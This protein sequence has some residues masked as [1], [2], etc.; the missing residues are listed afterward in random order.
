[1]PKTLKFKPWLIIKII[2]FNKN[3]N[4]IAFQKPNQTHLFQFFS[5]KTKYGFKYFKTKVFF[6]S[7]HLKISKKA[8]V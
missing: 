8:K 4:Y 1:M 5:T 3:F 2:C 6:Q 7:E